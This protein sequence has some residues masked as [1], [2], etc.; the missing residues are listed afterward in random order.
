VRA[1][2]GWPAADLHSVRPTPPASA[3]ADT[4]WVSP[5]GS[6]MSIDLLHPGYGLPLLLCGWVSLIYGGLRLTRLVHA[7]RPNRYAVGGVF[8]AAG[9]LALAYSC[10]AF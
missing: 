5:A 4:L 8:L 3:I 7:A 9:A 10:G 6:A 1:P 2:A